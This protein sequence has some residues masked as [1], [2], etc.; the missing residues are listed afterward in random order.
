MILINAL[1]INADGLDFKIHLR[2]D[3][4]RCGLVNAIDA[5]KKSYD[6][7]EKL[8]KQIEV[9]E[10]HA[11]A[12]SEELFENNFELIESVW[13]DSKACFDYIYNQI[14]DTPVEVCL[15]SIFQ[16]L[17]VIRDDVHVKYVQ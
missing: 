17:L 2:S 9:F 10:S 6:H 15:L 4:N 12:N 1:I 8:D 11:H 16:H 13:D 14:K 7:E 5:I 3:F